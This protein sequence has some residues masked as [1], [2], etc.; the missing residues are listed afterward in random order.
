MV[1]QEIDF[2][3]DV[4]APEKGIRRQCPIEAVLEPFGHQQRLE[5]PAARVIVDIGGYRMARVSYA[6]DNPE[7]SLKR[8]ARAGAGE[9]YYPGQLHTWADTEMG[10]VP[11]AR[12]IRSGMP[13]ICHD[14][15]GDPGFAP[16]KDAA[17]A[18][19]Y[20]S[21]IALPLPDGRRTF[22][23]LSIYSS[24]KDAFDEEEARLLTEL[25]N[26]LGYG[27]V[28][29]RTRADR[30]RIAYE[31]AHH[32]EIL[33]KSLE[34][35][36]QAIADTV[37]ARD[38]YT[39]GHQRRVDKLA[40]AIARELD[41]PEEKIHG[42]HLAAVI[43][44]LGKIHVPAEILAKPGKL[45]DI[46]F[47]FIKTHPQAGHDILKGVEFP[48]PIADMILQ[49]HERLDGSGY[50]QGLKAEQIL[51]EA[52]ILGVADVVEAMA[53]HRPYR[54][55]IGIDKALAEIEQGRGRY[56]PAIVDACV[57]LFREKRFAFAS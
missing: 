28:T 7:K 21:N 6:E 32:A 26:D 19:G 9:D 25:A 45:T 46:E 2:V 47:S 13:V 11:I 50:P 43:H 31:H 44:D 18:H 17:L 23:D 48:W 4:V 57:K 15:A 10:Q 24:E 1:E 54:A 53:S 22:G 29:L 12:A 37:E 38:P 27:I 36:I 14:I 16:W 33:Q 8:V 51:L 34:Q 39:A 40:M 3:A 56:D 41:L 5:Q 20:V 30:D 49:H 52:R 55:A 35:S 42:I